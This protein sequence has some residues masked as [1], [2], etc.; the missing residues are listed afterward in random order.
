[1]SSVILKCKLYKKNFFQEALGD[2]C[3]IMDTPGL[4]SKSSIHLVVED[5]D[6][7]ILEKKLNVIGIAYVMDIHHR[8]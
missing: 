3:L 1:M 7:M 2:S 4:D 5:I 6:D 8:D